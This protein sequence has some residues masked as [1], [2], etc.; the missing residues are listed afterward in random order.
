MFIPPVN[1][2]VKT[3]SMGFLVGEA[4]PIVW[5][6]MMVTKALK[7]LMYQVNWEKLDILVVDLPPG[8]GDVQISI[9]Q[10]IPLAGALIVSTPQDI[11]LLDVVKGVNMFK[12]VNVPVSFEFLSPQ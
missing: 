4:D 7:Q 5:R 9:A 6:G 1:Y 2:G 12:K 8:T 11:A 3:M 10:Q